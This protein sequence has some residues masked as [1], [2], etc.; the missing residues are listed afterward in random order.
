MFSLEKRMLRGDLVTLY[1]HQKGGCSKEG[2][3]H[4]LQMRSHRMQ[5]NGLKLHGLKGDLG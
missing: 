4:F 5:E 1:K 2:A 3:G